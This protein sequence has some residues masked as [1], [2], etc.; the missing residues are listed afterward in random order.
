M[1]LGEQITERGIGNGISLLIFAGIVADIPSNLGQTWQFTTSGQIQPTSIIIAL[2]VVVASV[3]TIVFF[4]RGQRRIPIEYS[5]RIIGRKMYGGQRTHLPLRVNSSGVIPPLFAMTVLALPATL[6]GYRVPG[7][8]AV[9]SVLGR[10]DWLYTTLFILFTV[11]FCY[12][13]TAVT[14]PPVDVADNL[15]KQGAFIPNIRPGKATA[16]YIEKVLMRITFGG[17]L[18]VALICV[19]PDFLRQYLKIPFQF[20][21]TSIMI[22]VG[23]ALDTVNQIESYLISRHYEGFAGPGGPRIQGR[24]ATA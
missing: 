7:M 21:G 11:F 12:F 19:L 4:E 6:A 13:Y 5:R 8:E 3:A 17:A 20:G 18:Y 14:F 15:K 10:G 16:D 23:V 22:V 2:M 24:R 1:W 9:Q